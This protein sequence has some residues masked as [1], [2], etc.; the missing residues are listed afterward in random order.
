M[1]K[2][3]ILLAALLLLLFCVSCRSAGRSTEKPDDSTVSDTS[4]TPEDDSDP[5]DAPEAGPTPSPEPSPEATREPEDKDLDITLGYWE[6]NGASPSWQQIYQFNVDG[7]YESWYADGTYALSGLYERNDRFLILQDA[8]GQELSRLYYS[9]DTAQYI[10]TMSAHALEQGSLTESGDTIAAKPETVILSYADTPAVPNPGPVQITPSEI[11]VD[12]SDPTTYRKINMFLSNFSECRMSSFS[13]EAPDHS[14]LADFAF[15]HACLNRPS[16]IEDGNGPSGANKRISEGNIRAIAEYFLAKDADLSGISKACDSGY[17]Y[18][19]AAN[20]C[21]FGQGFVLVDS[22]TDL[23][24]NLYEAQFRVYTI[25]HPDAPF[26]DF[27]ADSEVYSA[28][29]EDASSLF[30]G[31]TNM[32]VR[33][34]GSAVLEA[35]QKSDGSL[36]F[37]LRSYTAN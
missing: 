36:D 15:I 26:Y 7:S 28:R 9:A 29:P 22:V 3:R 1:K 30:F 6:T 34:P 17:Y 24:E 31:G 33:I 27:S 18:G 11:A 2:K 21:D 20:G 8:G 32:P 10:G 16:L 12:L 13:V 37:L 19:S 14:V 5:S 23:G 35:V 4:R 25:L